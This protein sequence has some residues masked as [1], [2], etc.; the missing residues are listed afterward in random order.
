MPS[1]FS[2]ESIDPSAMSDDDSRAC[3][4]PVEPSATDVDGHKY[5]FIKKDGV[6]I[7][8]LWVPETL[9]VAKE[10]CDDDTWCDVYP[11][12]ADCGGDKVQV[13]ALI[14]SVKPNWATGRD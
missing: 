2:I 3:W 1:Y 6:I 9:E 7:A 14:Q 13:Q 12:Y 10:Y 11:P 4:F 5:Y 8:Q